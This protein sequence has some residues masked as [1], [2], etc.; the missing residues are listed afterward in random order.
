MSFRDVEYAAF[1]TV[2]ELDGHAYHPGEHRRRDRLRDNESATEGCRTLRYG[3][4][5]VAA[6]CSTAVQVAR[7][8]RAG[9]W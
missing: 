6:P 9:G 3:W 2:V 7:A 8:L 4:T 1:D 5:D